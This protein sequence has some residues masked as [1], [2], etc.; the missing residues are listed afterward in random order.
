MANK[1]FVVHNGLEVG[2]LTIFGGNGDVIT[3]GNITSTGSQSVQTVSVTKYLM[4]LPASLSVAT[5]YKFGTL[6]LTSGTG[7]GEAL[8]II[9][10]GGQGYGSSSIAQDVLTVRFLNGSGTNVQGRFYSLGYR[11][12]ITNIKIKSVNGSATDT[13]W[14]IYGLVSTDAGNGI[15]EIKVNNNAKFTWSMTADS[16]PGSA[17]STLVVADEKLVTAS[18]N[19]NIVSGNLYVGGNIYQSGIQVSTSSTNNGWITNV[20]TSNGTTGPF[21]LTNTP[22]DI[23]QIAVW[24]NGIFQPKSTYSLTTNQLTFTEAPPTGSTIEVKIL[25]GTGAQRLST[26]SDINFSTSPTDGQFLAYNSST[27]K[28]VPTTSATASSV[29]STALTYAVTFGG[30]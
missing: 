29:K 14:D 20:I 2:S 25:G 15:A 16:D 9:L 5:W 18:A 23:D 22:A 10:T 12:A 13:S 19:V 3:T 27:G 24:W 4:Q 6:T 30:L 1:N 21:N 11:R 28:W 17:S 8:E 7:I 26:L